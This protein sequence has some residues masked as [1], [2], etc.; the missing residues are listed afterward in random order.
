MIPMIF[1]SVKDKKNNPK[2]I[3]LHT[4]SVAHT[5]QQW[6]NPGESHESSIVFVCGAQ[7]SF[8]MAGA[9]ACSQCDNGNCHRTQRQ[10]QGGSR[11]QSLLKSSGW[12]ASM[13]S[14]ICLVLKSDRMIP[15]SCLRKA[16][17]F[18]T[19]SLSVFSLSSWETTGIMIDA[20]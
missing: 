11:A 6:Q 19:L 14:L 9:P 10:S 17:I 18:P 15:S 2:A 4:N 13:L 8:G 12:V 5:Q 3:I 16:L 20:I 1:L 7:W